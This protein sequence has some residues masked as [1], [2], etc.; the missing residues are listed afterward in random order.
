MFDS[1]IE[2]LEAYKLLVIKSNQLQASIKPWA[3]KQVARTICEQWS[4]SVQFEYAYL[5]RNFKW[6]E[7]IYGDQSVLPKSN[8]LINI[9]LTDKLILLN[10]KQR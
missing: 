3:V 2:N 5:Q 7:P 10:E 8:Q 4:L 6:L 9:S 1:C